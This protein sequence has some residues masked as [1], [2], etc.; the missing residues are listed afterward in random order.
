MA[1]LSRAEKEQLLKLAQE[2]KKREQYNALLSYFTDSGSNARSLYPK[3]MLFFQKGKEYKERALI[4]GNRSGK[5]LACCFEMALHL[6]GLYNTEPRFQWWEGRKFE[7]SV[8][9]WS[10]GKTHETTRDILQRYLVGPVQD[11]GSGMIP[12]DLIVD[13]SSKPGVPN[14]IQDV[15][16]RHSSGGISELSFKSYIQGIDS[17]MGT[18]RHVVHLDEE[19]DNPMI[20]SECLTRTMTTNGIVML[21]FTPLHGLTDIVQSFLSGGKFPDTEPGFPFCGEV[22]HKQE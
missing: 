13:Y 15:Y 1:S 7:H 16:I 12:K 3:H 5:T 10:I 2:K 4:A 6:T 14:A 17:F 22:T 20:Y 19:A 18:S 21:S 9:A 8:L 11:I